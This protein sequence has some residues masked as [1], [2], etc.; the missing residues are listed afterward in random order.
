[1][2]YVTNRKE[3]KTMI[4]FKNALLCIL[5]LTFGS[6]PVWAQVSNKPTFSGFGAG[7]SVSHSKGFHSIDTDYKKNKFSLISD[8]LNGDSYGVIVEYLFPLGNFRLGPRWMS[9]K[10][11]FHA[12]EKFGVRDFNFQIGLS[13]KEL[14]SLSIVS[15]Y[16]VNSQVMPYIFGGL[17]VTRGTVSGELNLLGFTAKENLSGLAPGPVYGLGTRFLLGPK[18]ELGVELSMAFFNKRFVK[19]SAEVNLCV[20]LPVKIEPKTIGL[21]YQRRF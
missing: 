21:S 18:E 15:G 20:G 9:E 10:T 2:D 14:H 17:I 5:V 1:L 11:H 6:V 19:C 16:V 12:S 4:D 3:V 13:L 7:L 8:D